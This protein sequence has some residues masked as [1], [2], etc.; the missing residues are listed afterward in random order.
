MDLTLLACLPWLILQPSV[1]STMNFYEF[2]LEPLAL[3]LERFF[4]EK[5]VFSNL[6]EE[7][8]FIT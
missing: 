2:L 4:C 6:H 3:L 5:R 1:A 8:E 7:I